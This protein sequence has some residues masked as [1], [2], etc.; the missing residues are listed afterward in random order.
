MTG[1]K[2][3]NK[4]DSL[5]LKNLAVTFGESIYLRIRVSELS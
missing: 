3:S 1:F 4:F 5:A 2:Y